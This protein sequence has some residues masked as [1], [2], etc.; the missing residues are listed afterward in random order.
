MDPRLFEAIQRDDASAFNSLVQRSGKFLEQREADSGNTVL[1]LASKFGHLDMV[2]N[3]VKL[4]PEMVAA[5]N[6]DLETP[7]HEASRSGNAKVLRLLLESNPGVA[8]KPNSANKSALFTA[9]KYGHL[10][11]VNLLL[12]QP[13]IPVLGKDGFDQTCIHVAASGGHAGN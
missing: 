8:S 10:D 9:C 3:I 13:G 7:F 5:E 2:S 4:C 11:V 6:K 1:H 12:E